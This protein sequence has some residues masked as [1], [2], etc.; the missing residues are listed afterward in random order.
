MPQHWASMEHRIGVFT[1]G[2]IEL[3]TG[4]ALSTLGPVTACPVNYDRR[5]T[6]PSSNTPIGRRVM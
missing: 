3:T 4:E 1:Q 6:D 2:T 5:L